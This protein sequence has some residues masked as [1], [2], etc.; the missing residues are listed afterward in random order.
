MGSEPKVLKKEKA[1]AGITAL[2]SLREQIE[3]EVCDLDVELKF[4]LGVEA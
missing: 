3:G 4:P 1:T 2:S